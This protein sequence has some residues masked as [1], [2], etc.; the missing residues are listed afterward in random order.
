[1]KG[2][3]NPYALLLDLQKAMETYAGIVRTGDELKQGLE[4]LKKLRGRSKQVRVEGTRHYNPAWHYALDLRN[5]F[6]VSEAITLAGLNR[7]ESRG[8][9]TRVDHPATDPAQE[10]FNIAIYQD[11]GGMAWRKEPRAALP[12]DLKN[13]LEAKPG[14]KPAAD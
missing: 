10:A 12:D 3:E 9:H 7:T 14:E 2:G 6:T 8:A 13:L 11:K 4:E 5:L 1:V